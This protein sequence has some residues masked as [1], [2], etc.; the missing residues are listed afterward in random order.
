MTTI[1]LRSS[2]FEAMHLGFLITGMIVGI[3]FSLDWKNI[4]FFW[5]PRMPGPTVQKAVR[6]LFLLCFIWSTIEFIDAVNLLKGV[7]ID[8]ERTFAF[9]GLGVGGWG[10][11]YLF[12]RMRIRRK[13]NR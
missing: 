7:W 1:P 6:A 5:F 11:G 3:W 13:S 9:A 10:V 12:T 8:W 2:Q 4:I